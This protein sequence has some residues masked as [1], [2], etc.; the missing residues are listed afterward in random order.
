MAWLSRSPTTGPDR[1]R[2]PPRVHLQPPP[3]T[4]RQ[5]HGNATKVSKKI[6]LVTHGHQLWRHE[7]AGDQLIALTGCAAAR[8]AR[9]GAADIGVVRLDPLAERPSSGRTMAF[10]ILC[11]RVDAVC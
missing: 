6:A 3:Q 2:R 4:L 8:P 1:G 7:Q 5:R 11:S 9:P 10:R